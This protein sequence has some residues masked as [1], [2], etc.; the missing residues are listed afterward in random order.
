MEGSPHNSL[1]PH[2]LSSSPAGRLAW[3]SFLCGA[4]HFVQ[5]DDSFRARSFTPLFL[6]KPFSSRCPFCPPTLTSVQWA[7]GSRVVGC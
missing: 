6:T 7:A 3:P 4:L 1:R 2:S 5:V